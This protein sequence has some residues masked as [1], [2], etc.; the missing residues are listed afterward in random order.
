[1][2]RIR[3]YQVL[4]ILQF[5]FIRKLSCEHNNST[6]FVASFSDFFKV[7]YHNTF[8]A[9]KSKLTSDNVVEYTDLS[10]VTCTAEGEG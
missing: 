2:V 4:I 8:L 6:G 10:V 5:T 1:M 3:V 7:L 9:F